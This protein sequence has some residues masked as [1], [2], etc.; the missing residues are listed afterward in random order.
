[1]FKAE[2]HLD[3]PG[4]V[5]LLGTWAVG[6]QMLLAWLRG[7][8]DAESR[9]ERD[10]SPVTG[11]L[12]VGES[13]LVSRHQESVAPEAPASASLPETGKPASR[14]LHERTSCDSVSQLPRLWAISQGQSLLEGGVGSCGGEAP[15]PPCP[16]EF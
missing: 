6:G 9:A 10:T 7:A 3:R 15:L 12:L 14:G 16:S 5:L 1:M 8:G 13:G 4:E 2:V 11:P